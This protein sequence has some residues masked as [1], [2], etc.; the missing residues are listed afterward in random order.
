MMEERKSWFVLTL[1]SEYEDIVEENFD[2]T[3]S[4][5]NQISIIDTNIETSI[6]C[7]NNNK[8]EN[9]IAVTYSDTVVIEDCLSITSIL[10]ND[11]VIKC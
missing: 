2:A 1:Y 7:D 8:K 9:I 11:N 5:T 3:I 6:V 10:T 4:D